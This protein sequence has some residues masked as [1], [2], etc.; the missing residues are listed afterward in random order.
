[1]TGARSMQ[2]LFV[3][4]TLA[5]GRANAHVLAGIDGRWEEASVT[6]KRYAEGWG[7][8]LGFPG[9]VLDPQGEQVAGFLFSSEQLGAYWAR[10]DEFEGE[11]YERVVARVK[12]SDGS[13]VDAYLYELKDM[14]PPA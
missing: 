13:W 9:L 1:M 2:R 11:G 6:G 7:V 10:L 4:G 8:A 5:P 14:S 3:Y 12:R